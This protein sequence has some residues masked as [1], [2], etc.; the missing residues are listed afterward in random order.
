[1]SSQ[2]SLTCKFFFLLPSSSRD[3]IRFSDGEHGKILFRGHS[4]TDLHRDRQFDEV[5]YLLIWGEL[6]HAWQLAQFRAG[7][8]KLAKPPQ[9]VIDAINAFP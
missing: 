7:F 5:A 4:I 1:V 3:L 9:S 6:P 8:A 2:T